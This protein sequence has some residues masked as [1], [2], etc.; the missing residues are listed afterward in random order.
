[1][2]FVCGCDQTR[3]PAVDRSVLVD[4]AH[5][6]IPGL[7]PLEELLIEQG[8]DVALNRQRFTR[9]RLKDANI[10]LIGAPR[11][12]DLSNSVA[13]SPDGRVLA[14]G[15]E[16]RTIQLWDLDTGKPRNPLRESDWVGPLSF[17][18]NSRMLVSGSAEQSVK[19][20]DTG[21]GQ[22]RAVFK[23][24]GRLRSVAVSP[25]GRVV[26]SAGDDGVVALW[27]PHSGRLLGT[28][29]GHTSAVLHVTF[30]PDGVAL[31]T[32]GGDGVTKLWDVASGEMLAA[33]TGHRGPVHHT[34]F[35]SD[36][37]KVASA[38]ADGT[39]KV[40][41]VEA[42]VAA[43]TLM[44]EAASVAFS[45]DGL[46]LATGGETTIKLWEARTGQHRTAIETDSD[47]VRSLGFS[48]D[49]EL[50]AWVDDDELVQVWDL[51]AGRV[52]H[53]LPG[54][55]DAIW[56]PGPAFTDEECETVIQWIIAGGSL[57][58]ITD[59][60]PWATPSQCLTE[61]L[62]VVMSNSN[63]TIDPEHYLPEGN[64]GWLVFTRKEGLV[65]DHPVTLGRSVE[66]RVDNV[67]TFYGQSLVSSNDF[68]PLLP[69]SDSALDLVES[70]ARIPAAGH[71]QAVAGV[72][73]KGRVVVLGEAMMFMEAGLTRSDFDNR[74]LAVNTV[75][76]LSREFD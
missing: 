8:Y 25:D 18:A 54:R 35:A 4:R 40:W 44:E 31:A 55:L 10:L 47:W 19:L 49:G 13:I 22:I 52:R 36:G 69:L 64:M 65:G 21:S 56:H 17:A 6:N 43:F 76:W 74:Q 61:A 20:W 24:P 48:P 42:G 73:G 39:V 37:R 27:E 28:L 15:G 66:E 3:A 45:P 11:P 63:G 67:V 59:H 7:E 41:D 33:F 57:L 60:A 16:D 9:G 5:F 38:S 2:L 29:S 14:S 30:S 72:F 32:A 46:T 68:A 71:A 70:G 12:H 75:R 26:A 51:N 23:H 58:L 50:L 1:V 53:G 34:A 62:G